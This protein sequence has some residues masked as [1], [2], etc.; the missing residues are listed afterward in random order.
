MLRT[1]TCGDLNEKSIGKEVT[2][3]G[4]VHTRRDHGE[5]IFIDLRD[6]YGLTQVLFDPEKNR[7][8][9]TE[10]HKLKSEYVVRVK[11]VVGARPK[12]SENPKLKTGKIEVLAEDFKIL[13]RSETPPF[14]IEDSAK[15][16]EDT[17]LVHRYL[18]I[19][20][21][22]MQK[23]FELRHKICKRARDFLDREDY[24]EMETPILTKSTPEGA[25]DFLVPSR[26]TPGAFYALPQ[27]PQ[28]FKQILM[29]AGIDK[30]FQIAKCFRD[31]DLRA[32]RQPE[33]TQLDIEASFVEE[34]DIYNL[35]EGLMKGL[36]KEV[37]N[38]DIKTP[39]ER[40]AYDEAM[41]RFGSDKPDMRFGCE[42][43]DLTDELKGSE[44]K[45]FQNAVKSGGRIKAIS[46]P[47]ASKIS[48]KIINE[49]TAFIGE[50]GAKGL[51]YLK[52]EGD[53]LSSPIAKFFKK[54]EQDVV[55]KKLKS[56]PGDM[57]FMVADAE[58]T[59]LESLGGL[60][61][62]LAYEMKLIPKDKDIAFLWVH[63]FPLFKYN[64]E[65]KRWDT[66]HHPF[67]SPKD[68]DLDKLP[69]DMRS[70]RARA[71]DLVIS[72]VEV[73]SGSIRIHDREMQERLFGIIG[74]ERSEAERRFGFLLRAFKYGVPPHG[75]IALGLDRLIT[76]FT[77]DRSIREVI[78]F[79]KTQKGYCPLTN[80]P[81]LVPDGQLKELNI[82]LR[83]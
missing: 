38:I 46:T 61:L 41:E 26:L 15:V 66:E 43:V 37:L 3:C 14:E 54:D 9:H 6:K 67:T 23:K 48:L 5:L 83:K 19:R 68:H 7:R 69:K 10:V 17:R 59:A 77:N 11:G 39:F 52:V 31:E 63:D 50:F 28:L 78:A 8:L 60:R 71:Y 24:L 51:A 40:L 57:I 2:L 56:K 55:R 36:Y 53:K 64:D 35:C 20:R 34:E 32:D 70:I 44:F 79:P 45:I 1:H 4:W 65:E 80:A 49:L 29:V 27:S 21:P 12:D 42:I 30:Y 73:A 18:D 25:R 13:S 58:K 72:G 75:G 74:I 16:T 81:S 47:G 82:K 76:L 62:R 22:S 33:F